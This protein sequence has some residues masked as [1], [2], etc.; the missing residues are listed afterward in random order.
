MTYSAAEFEV[1]GL[2]IATEALGDIANRALLDL[3]SVSSD[4]WEVEVYFHTGI[5]QE[6][7]LIRLLDFIK[8]KSDSSLTGVSGSCL[9]VLKSACTTKSFDIDGSVQALGAPIM[10]LE[11]WFSQKSQIKIWLP[12]LDTEATIDVSRLEFLK[13]SGNHSKHNL[14]RLTAVSRDVANMLST[15]GYSVSPDMIPLALDDFRENLHGNL[16]VYYGTWLAELINN[17]RWGIQNYLMP[18][19]SWAY[20]PDPT[21]GVMYDYKYPNGIDGKVPRLWFWRLMNNIRS[22]PYLEQFTGVSYLKSKSSLERP[23]FW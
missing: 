12:T 1:I 18:T 10:E 5:H 16:F 17:I 14:S 15:H 9:D 13:I 4:P 3:R 20:T 22:R 7:F 6:I 2:C 19:F 23:E 21:G 8:E 11:K